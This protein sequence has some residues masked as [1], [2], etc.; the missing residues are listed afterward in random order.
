MNQLLNIFSVLLLL[1][2]CSC[3]PASDYWGNSLNTRSSKIPAHTYDQ[4]P[5]FSSFANVDSMAYISDLSCVCAPDSMCSFNTSTFIIDSNSQL[6]NTYR[7]CKNIVL[8]AVNF[9]TRTLLGYQ[10]ADGPWIN[11]AVYK[12]WFN[13]ADSTYRFT[14]KMQYDSGCAYIELFGV[15]TLW[16]AVPKLKSGDSVVFEQKYFGKYCDE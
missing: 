15:R 8:P 12:V 2:L 11:T 14:V 13:P 7:Y 5:Q 4:C 9:S 16:A 10:I 1:M 3:E 6:S